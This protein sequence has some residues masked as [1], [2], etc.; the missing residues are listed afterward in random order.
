MRSNV[1]ANSRFILQETNIKPNSVGEMLQSGV[2]YIFPT[3]LYYISGSPITLNNLYHTQSSSAQAAIP[4]D[5]DR[6]VGC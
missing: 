6:I 5:N 1:S 2:A 3:C 4:L